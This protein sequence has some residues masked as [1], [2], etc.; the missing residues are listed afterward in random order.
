MAEHL[1]P[2]QARADLDGIIRAAKAAKE[3]MGLYEDTYADEASEEVLRLLGVVSVNT[4]LLRHRH[5]AAHKQDGEFART[6]LGD[7]ERITA[8][9]DAH[10]EDDQ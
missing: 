7:L 1:T 8:G 6:V 3:A 5:I 10:E 4:A 2:E 9:A